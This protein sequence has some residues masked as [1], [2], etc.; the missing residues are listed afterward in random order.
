MSAIPAVRPYLSTELVATPRIASP[1]LEP[2]LQPMP[3]AVPRSRPQTSVRPLIDFLTDA[4]SL[5]CAMS[6]LVGL[7]YLSVSLAG[8]VMVEQTRR[9]GIRASVRAR[10]AH[11]AGAIL[12]R[13]IEAMTSP[14]SVADFAAAYQFEIPSS[15]GTA[16]GAPPP[17]VTQ[18]HGRA[19]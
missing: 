13:Q 7:T 5:A 14:K 6:V 10:E 16:S 1:R 17:S 18:S 3:R 2:R 11:H 19:K 12:K 4:T 15:I 8:Q 9:E